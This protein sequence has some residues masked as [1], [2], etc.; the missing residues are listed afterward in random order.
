MRIDRKRDIW[1]AL[2]E[3]DSIC[4]CIT[5]ILILVFFLMTFKQA[6]DTVRNSYR[7]ITSDLFTMYS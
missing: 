6:A 5:A 3:N 1:K 2:K 7:R 4:L